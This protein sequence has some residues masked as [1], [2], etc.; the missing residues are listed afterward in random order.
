MYD[1]SYPI[2]PALTPYPGDPPLA[3]TTLARVEADGYAL[4][5]LSGVPHIGTHIDAPAHMVEAGRSVQDIPLEWLHGHAIIL[6]LPATEHEQV[7]QFQSVIWGGIQCVIYRTGWDQYAWGEKYYTAHPV[8]Y[9][10][11]AE[12]IAGSPL[13]GVGMDLPS[14][15]YSPYPV[16]K[17]LLGADM[18]LLENLRHLAD[19]PARK[20]LAFSAIPPAFA[21]GCGLGKSRGKT[22]K[23]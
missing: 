4:T 1:L 15:D 16:H 18:Y 21:P 23:R 10:A 13:H 6:D 17:I 8:L 3:F 5:Q 19:L 12:A 14:P 7:A 20:S 22:M 9:P 2:H 11:L